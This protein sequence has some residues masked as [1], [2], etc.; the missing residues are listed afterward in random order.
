MRNGLILFYLLTVMCCTAIAKSDTIIRVLPLKALDYETV[1]MF[2][3]PMLSKGGALAYLKSQRAIVVN[4]TK[5]VIA[6]ISDFINKGGEQK[7]LRITIDYKGSKLE[8]QQNFGIQRVQWRMNPFNKRVKMPRTSGITFNHKSSYSSSN[9]QM[10]L[11]TLSG[12]PASLWVGKEVSEVNSIRGYLLDP[13][14]KLYRKGKRVRI[15]SVNFETREVGAK[16]LI[17]PILQADG[18]IRVE[19]FPEVSYYNRK[20]RRNTLQVQSLK[21]TVTILPGQ[22]ISVGSVV[23]SKKNGYVNLFGPDFFKNGDGQKI[24]RMYVTATVL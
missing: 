1:N 17:R 20:G 6:K 23:S 7:N 24:L 15:N 5:A 10:Q 3:R 19:I 8:S 16:L 4:D 11:V 2:C 22:K 21:T 12:Y 13:R 9:S 18:L 14:S